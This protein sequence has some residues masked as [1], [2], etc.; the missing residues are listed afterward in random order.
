MGTAERRTGL[1]VL[2]S[3]NLDLVVRL[4]ALPV[5]GQTVL[6]EDAVARPG[7]KGANQALAA[8][9]AGAE[10]SMAGCIGRDEHASTVRAALTAAGVGTD[11]LRTAERGTG[12]AVVLVTRDGE[13]AIVVSSGANHAL[14]PADVEDLRDVIAGSRLLL[15]QLEL[16]LD[17]V[18]R[19]GALAEEVGTPVVLNLAPA[20]DVPAELLRRLSVLVVNRSEAEHLVGSALPD[21]PALRRAAEMLRAR[22]P[23]AVVVTAGADGAVVVDAEAGS[24]LPAPAVDVV[25]TT[26]AGDAFVGVLAAH[27]TAGRPLLEALEHA[28]E[29]ATAAVQVDG[30]QLT[31]LAPGPSA[32]VAGG[33][34]GGLDDALDGGPVSERPPGHRADR[35]G[36][37]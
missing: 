4:D 14:G 32:S 36:G 7:G 8:A 1:L 16:P 30:A 25:D 24:H 35:D 21:V 2:G 34:T 28:M 13:N 29:A 12:L 18:C 20:T 3:V 10:V 33:S 5:P 9:L 17:V 19:A 31:S 27:L 22:G 6:G 26:G 15:M 23:A 37:G 11:H